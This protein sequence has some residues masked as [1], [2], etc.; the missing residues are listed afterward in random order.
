LDP[1]KSDISGVSELIS[2]VQRGFVAAVP[3]GCYNFRDDGPA[4]AAL[5]LEAALILRQEPL[6]MMK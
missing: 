5:L 3:I 4:E 1:D 2:T 6:E